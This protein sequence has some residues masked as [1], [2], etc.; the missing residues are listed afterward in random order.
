MEVIL[1][2]RIKKLGSPGEVVEVKGGF[3]RNF[4]IPQEKALRANEK[5]RLFFEEKKSEID[6]DNKKKL[7]AANKLAAS[8]NNCFVT[9]IRQAGEDG[10]LYGSVSTRDIAEKAKELAKHDIK[11]TDIVTAA[12]KYIGVHTAAIDLHAEVNVALKVIVAKTDAEASELKNAFLSS[13]KAEKKELLVE[14]QEEKGI[15]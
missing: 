5:N 8:V 15:N 3:A 14:K 6:A 2:E 9:I 4:L 12:I 13:E 7:E 10:K 11:H 1:L